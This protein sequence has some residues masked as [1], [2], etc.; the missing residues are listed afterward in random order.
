MRVD[1]AMYINKNILLLRHAHIQF[2]FCMIS[3]NGP[4]RK[5]TPGHLGQGQSMF[6]HDSPYIRKADL[7]NHNRDGGLWVVV[8]GRVYDIHDLKMQAPTAIYVQELDKYSGIS[9]SWL[10]SSVSRSQFVVIFRER[11][12]CSG[13]KLIQYFSY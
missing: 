3:E 13:L 8:D 10:I 12:S 5:L 7:E 2:C 6:S 4:E 11:M 9:K 1:C